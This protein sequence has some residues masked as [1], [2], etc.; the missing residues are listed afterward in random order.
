MENHPNPFTEVNYYSPHHWPKRFLA[1]DPSI[2]VGKGR[3]EARLEETDLLQNASP[4]RL[5]HKLVD[6]DRPR[7]PPLPLS[8]P[9]SNIPPSPSQLANTTPIQNNFVYHSV[10]FR[11]TVVR[12]GARE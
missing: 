3:R 11:V 4:C 2:R 12:E 1:T 5:P 7:L 9:V 8:E 10:S 6:L